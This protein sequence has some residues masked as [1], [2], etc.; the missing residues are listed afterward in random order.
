MPSDQPLIEDGYQ[1]CASDEMLEP[2][3]IKDQYQFWYGSGLVFVGAAKTV[4]Q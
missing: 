3:K 1:L 4:T 2:A